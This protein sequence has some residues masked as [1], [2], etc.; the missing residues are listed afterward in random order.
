[1]S[2]NG[3]NGNGG[4]NNMNPTNSTGSG[5][6][7]GASASAGSN[8]TGSGKRHRAGRGRK[9]PMEF[10]NKVA[11]NEVDG[12]MAKHFGWDAPQTN[13]QGGKRKR[14][15]GS[16]SGFS[17]A[18]K[19][20]KEVNPFSNAG[21]SAYA[22]MMRKKRYWGPTATAKSATAG[23]GIMRAAGSGA[24]ATASASA[25]AATAGSAPSTSTGNSGRSW[26]KS[27][28][29]GA[30][31]PVP[32][33]DVRVLSGSA[34]AGAEAESFDKNADY[35]AR[36][37]DVMGLKMPFGWEENLR[38]LGGQEEIGDFAGGVV[39][40]LNDVLEVSRRAVGLVDSR[41]TDL[42]RRVAAQ[43]NSLERQS[44]KRCLVMVSSCFKPPKDRYIT[45]SDL[46]HIAKGMIFRK[47]G[48]LL[49]WEDVT[50]VHPLSADQRMIIMAFAS[51]APGSP[52]RLMADKFNWPESARKPCGFDFSVSVATT[53]YDRT[54]LGALRWMQANNG[55]MM[56]AGIRRKVDLD[57]LVPHRKRII[58]CGTSSISGIPWVITAVKGSDRF[59]RRS[60]F[61]FEELK[62]FMGSNYLDA[63]LLGTPPHRWIKPAE[64]AAEAEH[65]QA[66]DEAADLV[67][68]AMHMSAINPVTFQVPNESQIDDVDGDAME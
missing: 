47:F 66:T 35:L 38:K 28:S 56:A 67:R 18:A 68:N 42:D 57:K 20:A 61:S 26:V 60:F 12:M 53:K 63:Y 31:G 16:G 3:S 5:S 8:G 1:M 52:F 54:L 32:V 23:G 7:S 24:R 64:M 45:D 37:K 2:S 13:E 10:S 9:Q 34:A 40:A 6:G 59:N 50:Q 62:K 22:E 46:F 25:G 48:Y 11:W 43:L 41:V 17:P 36:K 55:F 65:E 33:A 21:G 15:T 14:Q 44:K 58:D 19:K 29:G 39:K 4:S 27:G 51:Q 30:S 49:K